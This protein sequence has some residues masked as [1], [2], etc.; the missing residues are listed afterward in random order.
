MLVSG[1]D[2]AEAT[3]KEKRREEGRGAEGPKGRKSGG[4]SLG[5]L[6]G[7]RIRSGASLGLA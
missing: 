2:D 5:G 7:W 6:A 1:R 4:G 3:G